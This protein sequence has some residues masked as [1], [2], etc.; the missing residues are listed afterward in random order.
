MSSIGKML[1]ATCRWPPLSWAVAAGA[2]LA[3]AAGF[4]VAAHGEVV[5]GV[6]GV[7]GAAQPGDAAAGARKVGRLPVPDAPDQERPVSLCA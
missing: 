4:G 1:V 3:V 6:A 2:G 7:A 5:A